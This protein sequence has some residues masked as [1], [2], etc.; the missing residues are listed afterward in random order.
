MLVEA[1]GKQNAAKRPDVDLCVDAIVEVPQVKR[2]G[3]AIHRRRRV[4]G[5][6]VLDETILVAPR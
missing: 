3:G 5:Q 2:L 4:L 1:K 6:L